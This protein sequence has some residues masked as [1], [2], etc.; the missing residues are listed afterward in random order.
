MT[1]NIKKLYTS[2]FE[3]STIL[4]ESFKR[5]ID[6]GDFDE[7]LLKLFTLSDVDIDGCQKLIMESLLWKDYLSDIKSMVLVYTDRFVCVKENY[8]SLLEIMKNEK[9]LPKSLLTRCKI[10]SDTV[11][12][13]LMEVAQ[14]ERVTQQKI[15][16]LKLFSNYLDSYISYLIQ[17]YWKLTNMTRGY[18]SR[19]WNI[20]D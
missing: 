1:E 20:I 15:Q 10:K 18:G 5:P 17:V 6:L 16:T 3:A 8:E 19:Y 13:I 12:D 4:E 7:F 14:K 9:V 11:G 2:G